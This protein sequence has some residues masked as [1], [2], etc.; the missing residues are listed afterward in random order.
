[1][2]VSVHRDQAAVPFRDQ[3][4]FDPGLDPQGEAWIARGEI[5]G[6]VIVL[7]E[8]G[9]TRGQPAAGPPAFVEHNDI[10][11]VLMP[12]E[13]VLDLFRETMSIVAE[14]PFEFEDEMYSKSYVRRLH[15][16]VFRK[17]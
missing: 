4:V 8:F 14:R 7:P 15:A 9:G 12:R 16:I 6:A 2:L 1:M 11:S 10:E 5:L 3:A 13:Y 17:R